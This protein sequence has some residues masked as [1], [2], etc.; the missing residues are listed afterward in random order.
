M[1]L[2]SCFGQTQLRAYDS[3]GQSD[4]G[5]PLPVILPSGRNGFQVILSVVWKDADASMTEPLAEPSPPL[6]LS[7]SMT[8]HWR[9]R[10]CSYNRT[11]AAAEKVA[12][13]CR[14]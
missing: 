6:K 4:I 12:S 7:I 9:N 11:V 10:R 2:L 1:K 5:S 3:D 8:E 14:V 13:L